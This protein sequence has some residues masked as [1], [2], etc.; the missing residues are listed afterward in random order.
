MTAQNARERAL[1]IHYEKCMKDI[2]LSPTFKMIEEAV[3]EGL[4]SIKVKYLT[5]NIRNAL[6]KHGYTISVC[7]GTKLTEII[8]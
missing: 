3:E 4:F 2:E 5:D 7:M 8:W 1:E 6:K